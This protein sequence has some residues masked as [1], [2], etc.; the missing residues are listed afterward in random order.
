MLCEFHL[1][2]FMIILGPLK[3]A[4][5][6]QLDPKSIRNSKLLKNAFCDR[7]VSVYSCLLLQTHRKNNILV[8]TQNY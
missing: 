2:L 6:D 3:N 7:S 4:P 5:N 1:L 8:K